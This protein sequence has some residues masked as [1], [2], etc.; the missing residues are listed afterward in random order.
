MYT[1]SQLAKEYELSRS[2]L[3]YYDSIG[4]LKPSERSETGYRKY[5]ADDRERLNRI[6]EYRKLGIPLQEI[7]ALLEKSDVLFAEILENH[8]VRLS[9]KVRVIREQQFAIVRLLKNKTLLQEA[10]LLNKQKW[11]ALL[12]ASGLDDAAMDRW[13][14]EFEKL[15]PQAHHEFLASLGIPETEIEQIRENARKLASL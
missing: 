10:G 1:I 6:C 5:S 4:L 12:R 15:S 9:E 13:H 14:A 3:L 8:L 7:A 11:V 2:T